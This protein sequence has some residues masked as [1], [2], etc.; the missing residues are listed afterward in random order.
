MNSAPFVKEKECSI[1]VINALNFAIFSELEGK[2]VA[3][4]GL[5]VVLRWRKAH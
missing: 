3:R 4:E 2:R 1:D 5:R